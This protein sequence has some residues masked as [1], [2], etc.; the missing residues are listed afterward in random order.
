MQ[1]NKWDFILDQRP[2]P[3]LS[4]LL[5]EVAKIFASSLA[6]WPPQVEDFDPQTGHKV[7]ALLADSPLVPDARLY[8]EAFVLTGFE[9]KREFEAADDYLRNQRWM[10]SGLSAKEKGMLLFLSRFMTEQLLGLAEATEGRLSRP[11]LVTV[12]ERTERHFFARGANL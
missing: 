5:E 6:Q 3:L 7:A 12:L 11:N 1:P 10:A 4:H 8:S 9:L 2:V